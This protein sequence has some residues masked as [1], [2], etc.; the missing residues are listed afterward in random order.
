M[1][2]LIKIDMFGIKTKIIHNISSHIFKD[3]LSNDVRVNILMEKFKVDEYG[4]RAKTS[5]FDLGYGWVHYGFIRTIKPSK[6]LVIG[7]RHGYIPGI[8][9]Q[10]VHDNGKGKVFFVDANFGDGNPRA[11]TGE[12]YWSTPQGRK[13]FGSVN[14]S[15]FISVYI[16]TRA[17]Y[18]SKFSKRK[19]DYIYIDGDHSYSGSKSD[20]SSLWPRLNRNGFMVFHDINITKHKQEGLYGVH[21]LWS[22]IQSQNKIEFPFSGSGLGIVQKIN[23]YLF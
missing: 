4:H 21:R 16:M 11:W 3:K 5:N 23:K 14:L 12:A 13:L 2:P 10:A 15:Q 17:R 1:S 6:V 22:E 20:A 7:S 19:Y 8:L 18:L 9:A